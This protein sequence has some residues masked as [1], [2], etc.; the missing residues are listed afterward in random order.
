MTPKRPEFKVTVNSSSVIPFCR[1]LC[2]KCSIGSARKMRWRKEKMSGDS[3]LDCISAISP[4]LFAACEWM[5]F[6]IYVYNHDKYWTMSIPCWNSEHIAFLF[7]LSSRMLLCN[8]NRQ[9]VGSLE[10]YNDFYR[11][12]CFWKFFRLPGISNDKIYYNFTWR[13]VNEHVSNENWNKSARDNNG[14]KNSRIILETTKKSFEPDQDKPSRV[15][16]ERKAY[17]DQCQQNSTS[18]PFK[19]IIFSKEIYISIENKNSIIG[20]KQLQPIRLDFFFTT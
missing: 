14:F 19:P 9:L 6:H 12:T 3:G 17:V 15:L 4:P 7:Q 11:E 13:T 10:G 2:F 16:K 18:E 20:E 1:T 5:D 8:L